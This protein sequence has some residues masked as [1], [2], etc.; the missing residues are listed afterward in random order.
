MSASESTPRPTIHAIRPEQV[1]RVEIAAPGQ[2]LGG[3]YRLE[4]RIASGGMASIWSAA[5]VTLN[6]LVAVKFVDAR[7]G[8]DNEERIGRFLREAKVAASIRHKNV[9]DILDF[10]V[11]EE[12]EVPE[13]YMIMELLEGEALDSMLQRAP[14]ST[15]DALNVVRQTLSGLEA[16]HAAGIVHRDMKP[17]NVFVTV[18]EDG[19][20]ARVLDF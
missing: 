9:V 3:K 14:L 1:T 18:D 15:V 4:R 17:G 6:R 11:L 10:G 2:V 8:F 20:F 13:P 19:F 16:V 5:H 12:G 7:T